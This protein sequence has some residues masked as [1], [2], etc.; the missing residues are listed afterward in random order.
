V[1][2]LPP[3]IPI[4]G[5]KVVFFIFSIAS[6]DKKTLKNKKIAAHRQRF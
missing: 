6:K 1:V 2:W 4:C 3:I 5:A